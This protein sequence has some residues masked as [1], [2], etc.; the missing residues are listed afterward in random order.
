MKLILASASKRRN[1][2]L[3]RLNVDFEV[4][5]SDFEEEKVAFNGSCSEYVKAIAEGKALAV[6]GKLQNNH[7]NIIIG[8]DTIVSINGRI[9]GKPKNKMDAVSMLRELSGNKHQVYSGIAIVDTQ[10]EIVISNF[11]CTEVVFSKI[12][13]ATINWYVETGEPMDKAGAYGIQD[14]AGAFVKEIHGCYYNVVGLPLNKLSFM[15]RDMGVNL[16]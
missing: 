4:I 3:K 7:Q 13:D 11:Q 16:Y 15:L 10:K 12:E 2:L 6:A 9:L 8:C 14:Y 1:E 5:V